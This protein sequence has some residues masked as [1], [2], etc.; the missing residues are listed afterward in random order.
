[1]FILGHSQF[2]EDPKNSE[3]SRMVQVSHAKRQVELLKEVEAK[4]SRTTTSTKILCGGSA[5]CDPSN[6][7][8]CPTVILNPP[9]DSRVLREE[10]F[11]PILPVIPVKSREEAVEFINS[12][13]GTPLALYM[14]TTSAKAY[15]QVL[16]ACPCAAAVRNDGIVHFANS[17]LPI[18]GLG[19][20]G[21]GKYRGKYSFD[22]FTHSM[23]NCYRPLAPGLDFGMVRYHPMGTGAKAYFVSNHLLDVPE[24]P[25]LHLHKVALVFGLAGLV[26][27]LQKFGGETTKVVFQTVAERIASALEMAA[28]WLRSSCSSASGKQ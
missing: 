25:V 28:S 9:R 19:T 11:G 14:Y 1:L 3:L 13:R 2:G 12:I 20:S 26:V 10:I 6:R 18:G 7:Y 15:Q 24:V 5:V 16:D 17:H 4:I 23:A 8:I 21:Y 22:T 27:F